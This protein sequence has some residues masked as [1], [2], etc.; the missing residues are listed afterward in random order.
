[1][2]TNVTFNHSNNLRISIGI[3]VLPVEKAD[4]TAIG[5]D[6][7]ISPYVVASVFLC[8]RCY[9]DLAQARARCIGRTLYTYKS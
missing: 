4:V 9:S 1:M 2:A 5:A 3:Y 6:F 7:R 8:Y